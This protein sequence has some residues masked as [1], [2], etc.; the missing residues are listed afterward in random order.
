M[1]ISEFKNHLAGLKALNFITPN[2]NFVPRHFHITEVGLTT[3]HSVDCG[4]VLH[5]DETATIQIWVA[6][7]YEHRLTP[8][9]L[10]KIIDIS[11][12]V[13]NGRDPEVEIEYQTDTIGKYGVALQGENFVLLPLQ[14]DCRAKDKCG[15]PELTLEPAQKQ[16]GCC[17]PGGGCC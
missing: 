9:G 17:T 2:G 14:T 4:N 11:A 8:A 15:I 5:T 13:L 6:N 1:R 16:S 7:D 12:K 10:S 3:K